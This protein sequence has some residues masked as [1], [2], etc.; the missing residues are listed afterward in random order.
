M[1]YTG[2]AHYLKELFSD[3]YILAISCTARLYLIGYRDYTLT[4]PDFT[5]LTD[6]FLYHVVKV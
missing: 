5:S 1:H 2:L 4:L 3:S 6:V